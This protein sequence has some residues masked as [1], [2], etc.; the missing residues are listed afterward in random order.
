[1]TRPAMETVTPDS[2]PAARWTDVR[3]GHVRLPT[4]SRN[5]TRSSLTSP[6]PTLV[7][8]HIALEHEPE[9]VQGEP[10]L[11]VLD[12]LRKRRDEPRRSPTVAM[13]V[14]GPSSSDMRRHM[15]ST[16]PV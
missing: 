2:S 5:G 12:H 3:P 14:E 15:P 10:W 11:M 8:R 13:I 7:A 9:P 1:M 4:S 16:R 6:L